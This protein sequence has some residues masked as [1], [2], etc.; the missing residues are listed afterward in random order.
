MSFNGCFDLRPGAINTLAPDERIAFEGPSIFRCDYCGGMPSGKWT[1]CDY[2]G[3]RVRRGQR[4]SITTISDKRP[5]YIE[6][7]Q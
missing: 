6:I 2:C 4:I 1:N 7:E 5:R 3:A